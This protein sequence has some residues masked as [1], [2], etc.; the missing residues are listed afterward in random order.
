M[1][2][3]LFLRHEADDGGAVGAGLLHGERGAGAGGVLRGG[4][5][6]RRQLLLDV[7]AQLGRV[8]GEPVVHVPAA[9][10]I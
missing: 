8:L 3:Y 6:Q 2:P 10:D 9:D 4:G 1:P 5:T 7:L